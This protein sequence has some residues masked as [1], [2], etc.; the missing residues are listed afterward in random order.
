MTIDAGLSS[1]GA[2][3]SPIAGA[4]APR[5]ATA[6]SPPGGGSMRPAKRDRF[7]D[8]LGVRRDTRTVTLGAASSSV[9]DR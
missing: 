1:G 4:G 2:E 9:A 3:R 8:G 6:R 7:I 5:A